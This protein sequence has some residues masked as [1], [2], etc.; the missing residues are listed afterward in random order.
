MG[1]FDLVLMFMLLFKTGI[2]PARPISFWWWVDYKSGPIWPGSGHK[3]WATIVIDKRAYFHIFW[4][5]IG[6][7]F[8]TNFQNLKDTSSLDYRSEKKFLQI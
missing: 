8:D 3:K 5:S 2:F 7:T 1:D 6:R 4:I